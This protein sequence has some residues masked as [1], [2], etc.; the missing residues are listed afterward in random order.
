MY[1]NNKNG[2]A[3]LIVIVVVSVLSI[4]TVL[5]WQSGTLFQDISFK[6]LVYEQKYR[7]AQG[8]LDYAVEICAKHFDA[9]ITEG[10]KRKDQNV[11]NLHNA[12]VQELEPVF[13]IET[14]PWKISKCIK[15]TCKIYI[16]PDG[17]ILH[18]KSVLLDSNANNAN[19]T[20]FAL[21]C[22]LLKQKSNKIAETNKTKKEK[23]PQ[24]ILKN[25]KI[26]AY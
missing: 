2:S 4:C 22:N 1:R 20:V 18:I 13:E 23:D 8:G 11:H 21:S 9:F 25:W 17:D 19:K 14:D 6:R 12:G 16:K 5:F 15:Y 3:I 26:C 24:F 10:K 7:A